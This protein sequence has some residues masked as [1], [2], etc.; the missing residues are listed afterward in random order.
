M[1]RENKN[2]IGDLTEQQRK[3]SICCHCCVYDSAFVNLFASTQT[4]SAL[5]YVFFGCNNGVFSTAGRTLLSE[6]GDV[7][8]IVFDCDEGVC[9]CTELLSRC[10]SCQIFC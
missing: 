3:N 10:G 5:G 9:I 1:L 2:S 7:L 4:H 6:N 8:L